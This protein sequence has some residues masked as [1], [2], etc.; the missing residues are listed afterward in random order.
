VQPNHFILVSSR[1]PVGKIQEVSIF[2]ALVIIP[3][4]G[5]IV[6]QSPQKKKKHPQN[7]EGSV[8]P[9]LRK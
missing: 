4:K 3:V 9:P 8:T 5:L 6:N 1:F 7:R 2:I